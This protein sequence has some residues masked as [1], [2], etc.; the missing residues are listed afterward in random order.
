MSV[1]SSLQKQL[2]YMTLALYKTWDCCLVFVLMKNLTVL[3]FMVLLLRS[4]FY[5]SHRYSVLSDTVVL[6]SIWPHCVG[7][8]V[9]TLLCWRLGKDAAWQSLWFDWQHVIPLLLWLWPG[10]GLHYHNGDWLPHDSDPLAVCLSLRRDSFT[11]PLLHKSTTP[12]A[13]GLEY[14]SGTQRESVAVPH[15]QPIIAPQAKILNVQEDSSASVSEIVL[16]PRTHLS[17]MSI[18]VGNGGSL[19]SSKSLHPVQ[20]QLFK[21]TQMETT[22]KSFSH[23]AATLDLG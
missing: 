10:S 13:R 17:K 6:R 3:V 21:S 5:F 18:Q 22:A 16:K 23:E 4:F 11:S 15:I 9:L 19:P 7:I 2:R 20:P 12:P 14:T 8:V 1:T